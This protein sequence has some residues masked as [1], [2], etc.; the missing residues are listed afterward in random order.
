MLR[1]AQDD[2]LAALIV[3]LGPN[4]TTIPGGKKYG[5]LSLFFYSC[6]VHWYDV[7]SLRLQS[8]VDTGQDPGAGVLVTLG[9]NTESWGNPS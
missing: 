8:G 2:I 5:V 9:Q 1:D 3:L 7:A 4:K 6:I